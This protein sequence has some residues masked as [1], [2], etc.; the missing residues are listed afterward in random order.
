[1]IIVIFVLI[2]GAICLAMQHDST[3][4]LRIAVAVLLIPVLFCFGLF[5]A[6]LLAFVT[7]NAVVYCGF[8]A[9][10]ITLLILLPLAMLEILHKKL[11]SIIWAVI[12][13]ISVLTTMI[14]YLVLWGVVDV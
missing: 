13:V 3:H 11:L 14:T 5:M 12:V 10:T 8:L 1:M 6:F 9:S 4:P 2:V 7:G